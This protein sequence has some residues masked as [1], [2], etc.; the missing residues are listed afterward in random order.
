MKKIISTIILL[1]SF[2]PFVVL[3][4]TTSYEKIDIKIDFEIG[5]VAENIK[6]SIYANTN[7]DDILRD[8]TDEFEG[9]MTLVKINDDDTKEELS[10]AYIL[11][12]DETY[13]FLLEGVKPI[14]NAIINA[15]NENILVNSSVID[16]NHLK[17]TNSA[18]VLDIEYSME[19]V[20]KEE[21]KVISRDK[22]LIDTSKNNCILGIEF[23]CKEF[24]GIS[25]CILSCIGLVLIILIITIIR[26]ILDRADDKK[27]KDL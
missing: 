22:P 24:R 14:N 27:Y 17:I 8:R 4:E 5:T 15:S 7:D 25:Y 11:K 19:K 2:I 21:P 26:T 1:I 20:E 18:N 16:S 23:C 10:N 6:Y 9:N 13:G 3:A 12:K